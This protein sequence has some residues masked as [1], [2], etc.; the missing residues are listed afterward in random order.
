MINSSFLLTLF[1]PDVY[2]LGL[3]RSCIF[4]RSRK[5]FYAFSRMMLDLVLFVIS[6][7]RFDLFI[8][9]YP[10]AVSFGPIDICMHVLHKLED[11]GLKVQI[12]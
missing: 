7:T 10:G 11:L 3:T 9:Q 4:L 12:Q 6:S 1:L 8:I 5:P 2:Q